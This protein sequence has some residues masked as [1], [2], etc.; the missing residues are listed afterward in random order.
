MGPGKS[1]FA[2]DC[3]PA[4]EGR[5]CVRTPHFCGTCGSVDVK[6]DQDAKSRGC[7]RF[8]CNGCGVVAEVAWSVLGGRWSAIVAEQRAERVEATDS[9]WDASMESMEV[10]YIGPGD[11]WHGRLEFYL[12]DCANGHVLT[13][14]ARVQVTD[15]K[16]SGQVLGNRVCKQARNLRKLPVRSMAE[17]LEEIRQRRERGPA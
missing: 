11:G 1:K 4:A 2:W 17:V 10:E 15:P 12:R 16:K 13:G 5:V 7:D 14:M 8:T 6:V 3:R 9:G